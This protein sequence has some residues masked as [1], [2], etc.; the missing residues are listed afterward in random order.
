MNTLNIYACGGAGV[1]IGSIFSS[2]QHREVKS[3]MFANINV[4][5][6]DTSKSNLNRNINKDNVY[7]VEGLDGSG[8]KRDSNYH[9]L[10]ECSKEIIHQFKPGDFN[11]VL[12]SAS[13]G[14]GSV[15]GP[16]LASELMNRE[17]IVVTMLIGSTSS[18]IEAENTLKTMKSYEMISKKQNSPIACYY[19]E[20][21]ATNQRSKID[22][23]IENGINILAMMFSGNNKE[24]DTADLRN[25]LN[26]QR[27]TSYKP[28]LTFLDFFSGEVVIP[29]GQ[30][31]VSLV[32]L[33]DDKTS[34]EVALPVEYQTVGFVSEESKSNISIDL[35]IHACMIAGYFNQAVETLESKLKTYE[36]ARSVVVEKLIVKDGT[37]S[38]DEGLV[39]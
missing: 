30:S 4:Y 3:E 36:E 25:F 27:V 39:F 37:D 24:L 14:S 33:V 22:K 26:F 15:I 1:N 31:L 6:I 11:I 12:H 34:S 18:R 28:R 13:G 23:E 17:A 5:F 8:K 32:T 16:I 19:R 9:V 10:S 35:P 7:L 21:S 38:T 2:F 29:R 20:N